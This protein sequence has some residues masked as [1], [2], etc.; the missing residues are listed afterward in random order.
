MATVTGLTKDRMLE[1]EA[2]SVSGGEIDAE[3]HLILVKHSGEEIDAGGVLL[4]FESMKPLLLNFLYPVGTIHMTVDDAN[5][6]TIFGG[7]WVSWGSGRVPV[8][9]DTSDSDFDTVEETGGSKTHTLTAAQSGL[10]AHNHTQNAHAHSQD[11]HNHTVNGPIGGSLSGSNGGG[12]HEDGA[13]YNPWFGGGWAS[14]PATMTSSTPSINPTTATNN[15][16]TEA[17]A[18]EAHNIQQKYITCYMW[19]RTS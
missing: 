6:G 13:G 15:P 3:G 7:T 12:G 8:G 18:A 19:K 14:S 4:P 17:D 11:S 1:I 2:N 10:P 9:V 16:N 5:P